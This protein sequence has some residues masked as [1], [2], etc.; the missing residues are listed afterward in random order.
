[1]PTEDNI[2]LNSTMTERGALSGFLRLKRQLIRQYDRL[3]A[4]IEGL[5]R[6]IEAGAG[7]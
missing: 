3:R 5:Q 1:M 2:E 4:E 7:K 6:E